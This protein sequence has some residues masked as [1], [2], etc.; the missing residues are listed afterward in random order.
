[1]AG[2]T[3]VMRTVLQLPPRLME[4]EGGGWGGRRE[5]G[6]GEGRRKQEKKG[7]GIGTEHIGSEGG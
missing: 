1:M 3:V 5:G 6:R 2:V 7:E 4:G